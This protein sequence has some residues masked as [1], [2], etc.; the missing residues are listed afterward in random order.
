MAGEPTAEPAT[1][2]STRAC[3][4]CGYNLYG[5]ARAGTCPECG[6][7]YKR[8]KVDAVAKNPR[9]QLAQLRRILNRHER[10]IRTMPLWWL[11]AGLGVTACIVLDAGKRGWT[12]AVI[13][14]L[15]TAGRQGLARLFRADMQRRIESIDAQRPPA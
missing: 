9:R 11:A 5:L 2:Q 6:Q 10:N 1:I 14:T 13:F 7:T 8:R 3:T 4:K 12:L 15:I